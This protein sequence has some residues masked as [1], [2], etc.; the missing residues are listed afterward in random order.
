MSKKQQPKYRIELVGTDVVLEDVRLVQMPV[1]QSTLPFTR[2][3]KHHSGAW[4]LLHVPGGLFNE[5]P[6]EG[7]SVVINRQGENRYLYTEDD[8][9]CGITRRI[10]KATKVNID[11]PV[12]HL[13]CI[14]RHTQLRSDW[15][16]TWSPAFIEQTIDVKSILIKPM[17]A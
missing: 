11:N 6:D 4:M 12:F 10:T 2:I 5:V 1:S 9:G 15:R 16:L 7:I 17:V 3:E 13:D 14:D 8:D